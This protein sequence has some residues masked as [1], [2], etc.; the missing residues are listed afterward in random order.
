MKVIIATE[1][2]TSPKFGR[3]FAQ[4]CGGKVVEKYFSGPWAGFGSPLKWEG[5]VK[6]RKRG[7]DYYYGDHAY[8]GRHGYFRVTKN[9]LQ[10]SPRTAQTGNHE[11]DYERLKMHGWTKEKPYRKSGGHIVLCPQSEGWHERM[12]EPGWT[13]RMIHTLKLYTDRRIVQ[14]TKKTTRPLVDD[15]KGAHALVTHTSNAAVEALLHG[16]PVFCT[17]DCAASHMALSDVTN[18]E[19]PILPEG[20]LYM[21]AVLA[22]NQWSLDEIAAGDAWRAIK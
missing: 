14:R 2:T 3:A 9:A 6:A 8:F 17:G 11:P 15:L 12:G 5:F 1:E 7:E 13:Q 19:K 21:A 20:R 22:A 16:V 10:Y 4:G 18:I